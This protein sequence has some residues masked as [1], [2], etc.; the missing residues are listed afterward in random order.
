MC[1][2]STRADE[3]GGERVT[4]EGRVERQL[5]ARG[6]KSE[7]H[8]MVLVLPDGTQHLLRRAGGNAMRDPHFEAMEGQRVRL[9]GRLRPGFFLV[10]EGPGDAP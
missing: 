6:S 5:V 1:A 3:P 2:D 9:S 7:R 10:D 4:L 8:A